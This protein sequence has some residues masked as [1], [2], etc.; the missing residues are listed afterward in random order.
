VKR[1]VCITF[2]GPA[3][4]G[5]S[6]VAHYLS[7]HLGIGIFANDEI[8]RAVREDT[9]LTEVDSEAYFT[10]RDRQLAQLMKLGRDVV[11]DVSVDRRWEHVK[12]LVLNGGYRIFVISF[13]LTHEFLDRLCEAKGYN[14]DDNGRWQADH[15]SFLEQW[16]SDVDFVID[17][18][19]YKQRNELALKVV[20]DWIALRK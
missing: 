7:W 20:Q 17:S 16:G 10:E 9:L 12:S 14:K 19:N 13:D 2:A 15:K 8:R 18:Q 6:P 3:G 5:K 4:C 11:L 1:P